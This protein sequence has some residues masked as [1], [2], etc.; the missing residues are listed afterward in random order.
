MY[1]WQSPFVADVE[2]VKVERYVGWDLYRPAAGGGGDTPAVALVHGGPLPLALPVPVPVKDWPLYRGY[3]SLAARAGIVAAVIDHGLHS[4]ADYRAAF[5][6]IRT[7]IG[8]VRDDIG[9]DVEVIEVPEGQHGFDA[10]PPVPGAVEA[11][12][13][14]VVAVRA[15]LTDRWWPPGRGGP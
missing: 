9:V 3:A 6:D 11:V 15:A 2:P 13:A 14:G 10:L 8:A 7:A 5:A 1:P 4:P 12:R